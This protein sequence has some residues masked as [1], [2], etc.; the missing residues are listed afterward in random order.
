MST[1]APDRI[2]E[3]EKELGANPSSRQF[4]QLGELLRRDGRHRDACEALRRGLGF[5]PRYVAAW[6][7][8]GRAS[9]Q[10]EDYEGATDALRAALALDAQ[11]PVAWRLLGEA[12]LALGDRAGALVALRQSL[13]LAP[14]DG[15][16]QAAVDMLAADPSPLVEFTPEPPGLASVA[17]APPGDPFA[18]AALADETAGDVFADAFGAPAPLPRFES[19]VFSF[20]GASA[21]VAAPLAVEPAFAAAPLVG[22]VDRVAPGAPPEVADLEEAFAAALAPAPPAEEASFAPS[23]A[24]ATPVVEAAPAW[25][26]PEPA[27]ALLPEPAVALPPEPPRVAPAPADLPR[28]PMPTVTLARLYIQQQEFGLA[29]E[30]L[31]AVLDVLPD[32]QEARDLL[33]LVREIMEPLPDALPPLSLRERKIAALQRWLASLTLGRERAS[34]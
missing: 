3:L 21:P 20:S 25:T 10:C 11:N 12:R 17:G 24:E 30:V 26:E 1:R 29:A 28:G 16:L 27:F 13:Q 19:G 9:A 7:S 2:G 4:Y 33:D 32:H 31:E 22:T 5:N 34:T 6:V 14:G 8:L 18:A 15:V 23:A